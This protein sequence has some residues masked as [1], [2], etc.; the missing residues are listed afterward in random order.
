MNKAPCG[1]RI[2]YVYLKMSRFVTPSYLKHITP[3][4]PFTPVAL[5]CIVISETDFGGRT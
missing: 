5:K 4:I 1:C 2:G 3:G